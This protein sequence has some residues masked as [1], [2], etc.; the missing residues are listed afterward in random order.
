[1]RP[2]RLFVLVTAVLAAAIASPA[3]Q[4]SGPYLLALNKGDLTLAIV[5]PATGQVLARVPS[6]PDPHEVVASP[7]GRFAYITNYTQGNGADSTISVVDLVARRALTPIDLGAL[8]RP[9]G[10]DMAGGKLYFTAERSKAIGRIDPATNK[11]DWV[12]GTGQNGTHMVLASA[13]GNR[14]FTTNIASASVAI[15]EPAPQ[16]ARGQGRGGGRGPAATE[17]G[18]TIVPVGRGAEGFDVSPDG[19]ELWTANAQDASVSVIDLTAKSL[20]ATLP[21][22]FKSANRL[23]FTPD[24][25]LVLIAD[26]GGHEV[27]VI[28]AT[29]RKERTRI[30]VKGGAAGTQM[31]PDG[32]RAF[33]SIGSENAVA[34]I[35][36]KSLT[37]S[38]W[39]PTGTRPDGL[40]WAPS[41]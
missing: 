27:I 33:V 23:K 19:K 8:S 28:D 5:D 3:A 10:L 6:G 15:I 36:L 30:E 9:H 1:M 35:D 17:W 29:T 38:K 25:K 7:D 14:V 21:V 40:A 18:V 39:I 41:R 4:T 24:G 37:V 32:S 16:G 20:A 22:A 13:D 34:V 12:L 31:D 2:I 26:L 11:I